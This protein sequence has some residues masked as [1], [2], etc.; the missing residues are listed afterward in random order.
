M[1]NVEIFNYIIFFGEKYKLN[2]KKKCKSF[3]ASW[4]LES[5]SSTYIRTLYLL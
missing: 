3:G 2:R 1:F 4:T 5:R